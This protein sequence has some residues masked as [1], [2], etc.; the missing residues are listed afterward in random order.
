[1]PLDS[2]IYLIKKARLGEQAA[3]RRTE[4][5]MDAAVRAPRF[6]SSASDG[7][8]PALEHDGELETYADDSEV[9]DDGDDYD[10]GEYDEEDEEGGGG[11]EDSGG[12]H[13]HVQVRPRLRGSLRPLAFPRGPNCCKL[14]N[15]GLIPSRRALVV[16]D[17]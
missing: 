11:G 17:C 14:R 10:E 9:D 3:L 6:L 4:E 12:D 1:M 16:S 5:E 2:I 8:V 7:D 13:A 15:E